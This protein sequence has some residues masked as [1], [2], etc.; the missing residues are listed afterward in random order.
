MPLQDNIMLESF[1]GGR[2]DFGQIR[3]GGT[4][5]YCVTVLTI[6]FVL[7]NRYEQIFWMVSIILFLC[8]IVGIGLKPV[9]GYRSATQKTPFREVLK[10]KA[11][12]GMIAFNL[13]F[14]LG[15]NFFYNFYPI[16]YMSIGGDSSLIGTMMFA[17]ALTEIPSLL[18]VNKLVQRFG[19]RKILVMA[20]IFTSIR[21]FLLFV[22]RNPYLVIAAS[23]LHGFSYTAFSYC[24]ITYINKTVPKDLRATSQSA[25]SMISAVMSRIVFGY[26]GG[27]ANEIF[28]T[29]NIFLVAGIMMVL[30]TVVFFLW[31]RTKGEVFG[32]A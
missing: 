1:E 2:W 22:L 8:F 23:L 17:C 14:N 21:W 12:L 13:I 16:Y 4:I 28:G 7:R 18:V 27:V 25:N 24:I 29:N 9:R 30:A 32:A 5:G 19:I 20:G 11:L 15:L 3:M 6:G 26:I 31:A 10:N